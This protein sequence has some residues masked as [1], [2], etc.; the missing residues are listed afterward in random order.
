MSTPASS[1]HGALHGIA[2][3]MS[4]QS[5]AIVG[6]SADPTRI[7]GRPIATML[8]AGFKGKIYP[9]NPNRAEVQ[10]IKAYAAMADLPETPDAAI[11]AVPGAQALAAIEA[12]GQR[13]TSAAVIFSSGFAEVGEAGAAAQ[14]ELLAAARRHGMRLLGPNC[15][16]LF[17]APLGWYATFTTAFDG[18]SPKPG[19]TAVISQSGAFGSYL[20]SLARERGL[21]TPIGITTGNEADLTVGDAIAW[22]V[23]SPDV[24]VIMAYAEGIK[25]SATFVAA[26][27]AARRARK[28]VIVMKVGTSELGHGAAQSHTASVAG[29]DAVTDAV[30]AEF[31]AL[32]VTS[33]EQLLDFA[34]AATL[35]IFPAN[36]SLGVLTISGGVGVQIS[37]AAETLGLPMPAMPE[38]SQAKLKALLPYSASRNPVDCTAQAVNDPTL[39]QAFGEEMLSRGGYTSALAFFAQLT[40]AKGIGD[41][42]LVDM[43]AMAAK[44][45]QVLFAIVGMTHA[46]QKQKWQDA[47][48]LVYEDAARATAALAAMGRLGAAFARSDALLPAA[49]ALP[50]LPAESP[51]EA[52]AK[53]LLAAAGVP[54]SPEQVCTTADAA[55]Q[56]AD[57]FAYPVV[58]KIVSPDIAH[59][60]EIGGVLLN[61]GSAAAVREGFATLMAR[62]KDKAPHARLEGVLVAKQMAGGVECIVGVHRDPVFGPVAA[63]G[64]GGIFVEVLRDVV[65][66]RCP[67][68]EAEA[69][70]MIGQLRAASVLQGARGKPPADVQALAQVLAKVSQFAHAAGERL[71]GIDLNPVLVLPQGQGAYALDALLQLDAA[72]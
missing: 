29:D 36:N 20:V 45:P 10:G 46:E 26:L 30:L 31:G 39:L 9:I 2:A 52:G 23:D 43:A 69:E 65:L 49:L 1:L 4:P 13:G 24:D 21:G 35:R 41:K 34:E 17:N 8:R 67:F 50:A 71:Q 5:V 58:L 56:A 6:A 59:K 62:A 19:R 27:A 68:T 70:V 57:S 37:D 38:A 18:G 28:P 11:I 42:L 16:G 48:F 54:F 15:L 40:S 32:R 14:E 61:V 66:R 55:V 22:C 63:I 12:L 64:L 3:L 33:A 60:T 7:G 44:H 25:S 72:E 51:S 47:G 53:T